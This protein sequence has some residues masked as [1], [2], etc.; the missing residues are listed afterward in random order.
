MTAPVVLTPADY[1]ELRALQGD[2]AAAEAD[3]VKRI[4]AARERSNAKFEALAKTH[5]FDPTGMYRWDDATCALIA[6]NGQP[7]E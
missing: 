5:G 4:A 3:A 1:W 7:H 2:I 6:Q